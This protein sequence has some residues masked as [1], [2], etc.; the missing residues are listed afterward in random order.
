MI[1]H[2]SPIVAIGLVLSLAGCASAVPRPAAPVATPPAPTVRPVQNNNLIGSSADA[3]G[4]L[5]GKPRIDVVEGAGRKLQFA[6]NACI[7]DI[8]LYA[9][10]QG[11]AAVAS[12][13]DART[14]E[15]RD[16]DVNS[17]A[18]ALRR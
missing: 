15:G 3:L 17:C 5:F 9:P 6:G 14:P 16:A 13:V 8:Y 4:R 10:R 11:A 2:P 18:A 7:L 12:H 1:R